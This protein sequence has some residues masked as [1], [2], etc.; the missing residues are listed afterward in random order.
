MRTTL[1][2]CDNLREWLGAHG[3]GVEEDRFSGQGNECNWLA[4]KRT[5]LD[6]RECETNGGKRLQIVV[7]PFAYTHNGTTHESSSVEIVG[8]A[9]DVWFNQQAYSLGHDVLM[10]RLDDI[11][12]MLISA[13]NALLP[14]GSS[15]T[16]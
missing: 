4:Y 13:W 2:G 3:F 14:V 10:K 12:R 8:E 5:K 15:A 11:E 1:K 9:G 16:G 7:K 6:A